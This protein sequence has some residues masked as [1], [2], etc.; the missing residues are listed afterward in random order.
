MIIAMDLT[1]HLHGQ[2]NLKVQKE[3]TRRFLIA[4]RIKWLENL[5]FITEIL[6]LLISQSTVVD[7]C[8]NIYM[9]YIASKV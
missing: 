4:A 9:K 7:F 5:V 6:R 3:M 2:E 8:V 1:R